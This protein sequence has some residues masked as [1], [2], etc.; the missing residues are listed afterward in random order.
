MKSIIPIL[1]FV[2]FNEYISAQSCGNYKMFKEGAMIEM[3]HYDKKGKLS[4]KTTNNV[5]EIIDIP[6]GKEADVIVTAVNDEGEQFMK[7]DAKV[8]CQN[9]SISISLQN[10]MGD[11][12]KNFDGMEV[13]IDETMLDYPSTLNDAS[14]LKDGSYK[15]EIFSG[16]MK[17]TTITLEIKDR[18]VV[19]KESIKTTAGSFDCVKMTYTTKIKAIFSF[20]SEVTEWWSAEYGTIKTESFKNGKS[21]GYSELS[22]MK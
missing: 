4:S 21:Q 13:K 8:K 16:D 17:I 5:I 7:N 19:G 20:T 15:A 22:A 3:S 10:M 12:M 1:L 2:F 9:G 14:I 18:K 11:Q 6:G